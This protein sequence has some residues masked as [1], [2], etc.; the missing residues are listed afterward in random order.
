MRSCTESLSETCLRLGRRL[1]VLWSCLCIVDMAAAQTVEETHKQFLHGDYE[2]VIRVAQKKVDGGAYPDD[3]R[4]M[5]VRSLLATGRY[6]EAYTN[7][8][9]AADSYNLTLRLLTRETMI[10]ENDDAG[11][12]R[13]LAQIKEMIQRRFGDFQNEDAPA[14]GQALLLLGVE[15]RLVLDN[16]FRRA[17]KANPPLREAFLATGQLALDKHDYALAAD[18]FRA[19]SKKFPNDPDLESG[20]AR[21]FESGDQ[22]EMSRHLEAAL[23]V[24]PRHVPSLLLLADHLIDAEEYDQA[25][26]QLALALKVNPHCPEALAYRS[27]LALLR[28]DQTGAQQHR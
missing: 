11:A 6:H 2:A 21:A 3:W 10:Y 23:K 16:C 14:L 15:P 22:A 26:Q 5:L 17:E 13:Q 8:A 1:G 20:L 4:I 25:G 18:A 9:P 27:V 24:N 19:G 12:K 28:N 7:A